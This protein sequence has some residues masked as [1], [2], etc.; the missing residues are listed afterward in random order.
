MVKTIPMA[1]ANNAVLMA[2]PA[3]MI[4]M[5]VAPD[6]APTAAP[7]VKVVA[8]T[9]KPTL[10]VAVPKIPSALTFP[11]AALATPAAIHTLAL[12]EEVAEEVAATAGPP[13]TPVTALV[14]ALFPMRVMVDALV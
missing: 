7:V 9:A 6:K 4:P 8:D 2:P 10:P 3:K 11:A 13:M 5:E 12:A 1:P 14:K